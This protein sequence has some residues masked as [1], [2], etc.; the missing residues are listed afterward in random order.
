MT[1]RGAGRTAS[2]GARP[3]P[4]ALLGIIFVSG[5]AWAG[6][7]AADAGGGLD[8]HVIR[9]TPRLRYVSGAE[10]YQISD[11]GTKFSRLRFGVENVLAE[12]AVAGRPS[13]TM[14]IRGEVWTNADKR[15]G[16]LTDRDYLGGFGCPDLHSRSDLDV[17]I[18]GGRAGVDFAIPTG[19]PLEIWLGPEVAFER[20]F[21]AADKTRY[22]P[23]PC[24]KVAAFIPER[25]LEYERNRI[26]VGAATRLELPIVAGFSASLTVRWGSVILWDHDDHLLRYKESRAWAWGSRGGVEVG[27]AFSP[28]PWVAI[29][30]MGGVNGYFAWGKQDQ[31]FYAGPNAGV[32]Y[33]GIDAELWSERVE[34]G[35]AIELRF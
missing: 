16:T 32:E 26:D 34:A 18:W 30:G 6:E 9:L 24:L 1:A 22:S 15:A 33:D 31:E 29:R 13:P 12:L 25:A 14:E 11:G 8:P 4:L 3:A 17:R 21:F 28:A 10:V 7:D 23:N 19:C 2:G 27:F 20:T 5:P 35:A